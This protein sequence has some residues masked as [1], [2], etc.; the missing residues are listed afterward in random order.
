[1]VLQDF[2]VLT[3][4]ASPAGITVYLTKFQKQES[5]PHTPVEPDLLAEATGGIPP[6]TRVTEEIKWR[7]TVD[8]EADTSIFDNVDEFIR[9]PV[10]DKIKRLQQ[11]QITGSPDLRDR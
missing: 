4:F 7:P 2:W 3:G 9:L 10:Y 1:V 5:A 11:E 8:T 6:T